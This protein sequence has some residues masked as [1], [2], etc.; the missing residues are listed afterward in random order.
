MSFGNI[1][2]E[3]P[4]DLKNLIIKYE[5]SYKKC[6]LHENNIEFLERCL[7]DNVMPKHINYK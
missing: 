2:H 3:L 4:Y 1:L 7:S 5:R 6:M